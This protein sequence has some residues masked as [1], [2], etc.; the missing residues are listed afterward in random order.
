MNLPHNRR[1]IKLASLF[2]YI[3]FNDGKFRKRFCG[4]T[5][6]EFRS[7]LLRK[8][9]KY[10]FITQEEVMW[11]MKSWNTSKII[12]DCLEKISRAFFRFAFPE[13]KL[14]SSQFQVGFKI[15]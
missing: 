7:K 5:A 2:T 3:I 14:T 1:Y 6:R 4:I 15:N 12:S 10:M 8:R 11:I 13:T 9:T